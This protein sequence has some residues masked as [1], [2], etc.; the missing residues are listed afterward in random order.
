MSSLDRKEGL[1]SIPVVVQP[2]PPAGQL[3]L[4]PFIFNNQHPP[5][6][7]PPPPPPTTPQ[8]HVDSFIKQSIWSCNQV[9]YSI[10]RGLCTMS[11]FRFSRCF[12]SWELSVHRFWF[13]FTPLQ[14]PLKADQ[15]PVSKSVH[16]NQKCFCAEE[17]SAS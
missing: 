1:I 10:H 3:L 5:P 13:R 14:S 9:Q 15:T 12:R 16:N 4:L 6:L 8:V 17:I 2:A 11:L 7:T